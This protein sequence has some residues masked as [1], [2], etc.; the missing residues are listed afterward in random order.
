MSEK[1]T[2]LSRIN[3]LIDQ[4]IDNYNNGKFIVYHFLVLKDKIKEVLEKDE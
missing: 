3:E 2:Y 1:E 4:C